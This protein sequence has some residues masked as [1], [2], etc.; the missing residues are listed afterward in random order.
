MAAKTGN[1][2]AVGYISI[3]PE[4]SKIAPGVNKAFAGVESSMTKT[5]S[6]MG[7]KLMSGVG[8]AMKGAAVGVGGAVAGTLGTALK[9]GFD[10]LNAIDQ[11]TA[12]LSGLGNSAEDVSAIMD[13]AMASVKG[14]AYG[15][16]DAATVAAATVAA[17]VKPGQD[18]QRT[19]KLVGDAASIAGTDMS[20]M[21]S[22]F[23]KV[24]TSNKIQGDV[25]AQLS[26]QGIPIVQL[27]AEE[28]GKTAEEV[29]NLASSGEIDFATFQNAMEAG[30]GGA[31]LKAGDTFSGAMD[32]AGAALGRLGEAILK[33]AFTAAPGIIGGITDKIDTLTN[34]TKGAIEIFQ[35]GDFDPKTWGPLGIEED[36]KI[37]DFFF[38]L[39]EEVE[40]F[41]TALNGGDIDGVMGRLGA[42][43]G[44][45]G[46]AITD[47]MPALG[48]I[49]ASLGEAGMKAAIVSITGAM[50]TLAPV[51]ADILVPILQDL[52]KWMSENQGIVEKL[53]L[54]FVGMKT[55][56]TVTGPIGKVAKE[57]SGLG[58]AF[59]G[60]RAMI[61]SGGGI[62]SAV[63]G[64]GGIAAKTAPGVTKLG[65]G[66][67]GLG[68]IFKGLTGVLKLAAG[69]FRM[70]GAAIVANPI[71]AIIAAV[72]AVVAALTL[73]FTKTETGKRIWA[74]FMDVLKNV[75]SWLKDVFAPVWDG[76]KTVVSAL[77]D[78]VSACFRGIQTVWNSVLKPVLDVL[79]TVV[80]TT[81]G[82][83]GTLILAP[84]LI[85]W[86]LLSAG[87]SAAWTGL[88]KPAWDALAAAAQWMWDTILMPIF[89]QYIPMAWSN[90][91]TVISV[92]WNS[93]IKPVWDALCVA[94][95]W[96]WTNVLQPVWNAITA[97]WNFVGS[98][99]RTVWTSVIQ[100]AWNALGT[101]IQFVW[102]NVIQPTW[103]ALKAALQAVGDFFRMIWDTVI[104]PVWD[105]LGDGIRWVI[106]N[107]IKPAFDT[108]KN[109]LSSVKDFFT[110]IVDGIKGV[111]D[112]LR[113]YLAKPINFMIT[114]VYNGGILKAWNTVAK[115]IPGLDEA[116]EL[117]TI[118]EHAT[119]GRI[120]G[121]GTGTSDDV[122]MW[123]SNGEHMMTA[124]EVARAGGHS[125]IYAMRHLLDSGQSFTW[126]AG[127]VFSEDRRPSRRDNR[128]LQQF[129]DG[130][131]AHA[132]GGEVRPEWE[133]QLER[134]HR[135]AASMNGRPYLT[136]SQW[137]NGGD[138]SGYMS[139]IASVIV[140]AEPNA[141]H[142]ATPAFPASQSSSVSAGNQRWEGG[143]GPGM[144]IGVTGG[145]QSGGQMGHTAGTL[146]PVGSFSAVN[147]ES[148]GSH[149]NV[150]Y[151]GP[152]AGADDGQWRSGNYHLAIGAD[153]AFESAGGPSPEQ[154]KGILRDKVKEIF[155]KLLDPIKDMFASHVGTPPPEWFNIPP[156]AM[157]SSKDKVID[158]LFD[159]IEDLGGLLGG[160]YNK[161]KDFVGGV[162]SAITGIFRDRGGW[163]PQGTHL[164]TNH[165][166]GPEAILN[167]EQLR[168]VT[169]LVGSVSDAVVHGRK[170]TTLSDDDVSLIQ[171]FAR[172]IGL[173]SSDEVDPEWREKDIEPTRWDLVGAQIAGTAGNSIAKEFLGLFGLKG[174]NLKDPTLVDEQGR[175]KKTDTQATSD[176]VSAVAADTTAAASVD[177]TEAVAMTDTSTGTELKPVTIQ[178]DPMP[179]LDDTSTATGGDGT[180]KGTVKAIFA[181]KGW[182]GQKW[183]DADWIIN[184]ES[185]WKIDATNPSSGAFGLF[186]FNPSS[187]T[188][189]EYLPDRSTDPAVQ[190]K[191]GA[192]YITDRYQA[193]PSVARQFWEANGWYDRGGI[194]PGVGL[195]AKKTIRPERVLSPRQTDAFDDLV[196]TQ[197]PDLARFTADGAGGDH[198][199]I[200]VDT[201]NEK[202]AAEID[203]KMARRDRSRGRARRG[204]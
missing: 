63:K 64:F 14:T 22:I 82:V 151:G 184:K 17:G 95:Q 120:S 93:V 13:D 55:L 90:L 138:C 84:L 180:V 46:Q 148:G 165:T 123:G 152:A 56:N 202:V 146:G 115:F 47:V 168:K 173:S 58:A 34:V 145:P 186:Q 101:G 9:K 50:A 175:V 200:Y 75:W 192:R 10:R 23:N 19:L 105:A 6:G 71:G 36:S 155:D 171:G 103:N 27:L 40:K 72:V 28:M 87:I 97:A 78:A 190:G 52:A 77:G 195:M 20:S 157:S 109:A 8:K 69:G 185:S 187:G 81:L 29:T 166:G 127:K 108:L 42:S 66:V 154:K 117:S 33:P 86:N 25:I 43:F 128:P 142:W 60:A 197:L 147:V 11:A 80:S 111:W 167:W 125:A 4:T 130:L 18:L 122:L 176:T 85:A 112:K 94:A 132:D 139:A 68:G 57:V 37:I 199:T 91:S 198:T 48:Q 32:N 121:P 114:T 39:R 70:L 119:G 143:L 65:K 12:K 158:F 172:T 149:G 164:V 53:V 136:G 162:G 196:Y 153:G 54:A 73:F 159:K 76:L 113:G 174:T 100:P 79:W 92:V 30:M 61:T 133:S 44:T 51:V 126:D 124:R 137:P 88:I 98:V 49:T 183:T 170:A 134:G 191:A 156:K 194:A 177:T 116:S 110:T 178:L 181:D 45:I 99:F 150:A 31:A 89:T 193:N 5:G 129:K 21:G 189:Q 104:K 74:S 59:K 38:D 102:T 118:P 67:M 135:W 203:R 188:L 41:T 131:Q 144:S 160:A 179:D 1:E 24:A 7:S 106:D 3:I 26:D 204:L 163:L 2:L 16:G 182:T 35:T 161:A 83:I 96:M 140:G 107:V 141:G 62:M 169:D 15:L 201:G